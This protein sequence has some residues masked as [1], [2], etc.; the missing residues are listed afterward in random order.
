MF[1]VW[2]IIHFLNISFYKLK[3]FNEIIMKQGFNF[4]LKNKCDCFF[5]NQGIFSVWK[6]DDFLNGKTYE[7]ILHYIDEIQKRKNISD[8]YYELKKIQ[9]KNNQLIYV[10]DFTP[11]H[12][13][14]NK[15]GRLPSEKYFIKIFSN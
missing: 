7:D 12:G 5:K 9:S 15:Y 6:K 14:S 1:F 2:F 3:V 13:S 8:S 4:E 11:G 10:F